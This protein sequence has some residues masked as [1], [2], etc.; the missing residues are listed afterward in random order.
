MSQQ[1]PATVDLPSQPGVVEGQPQVWLR[2]EALVVLSL[3]VVAYAVGHHSW[4]LFAAVVFLP[5]VSALGYLAGSRVGATCYNLAHTY[6]LPVILGIAL[7]FVGWS[8]SIPLIWVAH[9]GFDRIL[10]YGLKYNA[11]FGFTHLG[12]IGKAARLHTL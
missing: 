3:A 1:A 11:G 12:R 7:H 9:I 10:G 2:I 8:L 6:A 5:D 4:L